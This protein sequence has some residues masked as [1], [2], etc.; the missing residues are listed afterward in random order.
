MYMALKMAVQN[1]LNN[2]TR[3]MLTMLGIIIAV[4]SFVVMVASGSDSSWP[5]P[6]P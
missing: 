1:I 6:V 2:K 3:S 5:H 4:L